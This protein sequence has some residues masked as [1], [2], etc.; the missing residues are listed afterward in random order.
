MSQVDQNYCATQ[1]R[2]LDKDRY[3]ATLLAPQS[4]RDHLFSLYAFNIEISKI[5]ENVSEALLGE[6]RLTWWREAIAAI[7]H[8]DVSDHPV[9]EALE[10]TIVECALPQ[11]PFLDLID[12]RQ[13]DLYD[14]PM[15]T[16]ADFDAY[17]GATS[18]VLFQ[19]ASYIIGGQKAVQATEVNGHAGIAYALQGLIRAAPIHAARGQLYLPL[20]VLTHSN[21][22]MGDYYNQK[23]TPELCSAFRELHDIAHYHLGMAEDNMGSVPDEVFPALLPASLIKPYLKKVADKAYDPFTR[24]IET[25]QL[26]RQWRLWRTASSG[27]LY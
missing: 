1:V 4:A 24:Q 16:V 22:V 18:S 15:K 5:R 10:R 2:A 7:Y 27:K 6:M 21:V 9:V 23:M 14:E 3:L 19:L 12:A 20:E 13:F 8:G 17:A 11:Q 26:G 25:A